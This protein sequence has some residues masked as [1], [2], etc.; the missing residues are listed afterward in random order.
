MAKKPVKKTK[1]RI[2]AKKKRHP[3][4]VFFVVLL[5]FIAIISLTATISYFVVSQDIVD[6]L[7]QQGGA[8][9]FFF[10]DLIEKIRIWQLWTKIP[11]IVAGLPTVLTT[12]ASSLGIFATIKNLKRK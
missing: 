10:A 8:I 3:L 6:Y 5:I 11:G 2:A 1:I 9:Q 12:I 7:R 4:A